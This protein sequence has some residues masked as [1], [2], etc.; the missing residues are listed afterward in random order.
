LIF[1]NMHT[2]ELTDNT[3]YCYL[4]CKILLFTQQLIILGRLFS[5]KILQS[6]YVPAQ[7]LKSELLSYHLKNTYL[8]NIK[9][10]LKWKKSRA[11]KNW[12]KR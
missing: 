3:G 9:Q 1:L 2:P 10:V 5:R 8:V 4:N 11:L 6:V 7:W 12:N